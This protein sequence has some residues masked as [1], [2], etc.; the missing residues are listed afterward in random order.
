MH[1]IRTVQP[2]GAFAFPLGMLLVPDDID[3]VEVEQAR[4][5]LIEARE[6]VTWPE[7]LRGHELAHKGQLVEAAAQFA[8]ADEPISV[9]NRYVLE[10]DGV[11]TVALRNALPSHLADLVDVVRYTIGD[12]DHVPPASSTA[13]EV[14]ALLDAARASE[15][16]SH[17]DAAGAIALLHDAAESVAQSAAPLSAMLLGNAG[18][19]GHEFALDPDQALDDL[20]LACLGLVETDLV[21]ARAELHLRLGLAIH[22]AAAAGRRPL[23]DAVHEYYNA[24]QLVD[25]ES[26]P[27]T[28]A[29]A[30]LNLGAAYLTMPMIE[31]TDQL[32]SGI[33]MQSLRAALGVFTRDEHPAEW[34]SAT[35]N[36]A[37][38]L[39][40]TPST[41]QGDNI[42][43]AVERYEE[44]LE[45]RSRDTDP[46]GR[47]RILANLGNALAHLGIFE[48]AKSRLYEA[49]YLFEEALDHDSVMAVRSI[50]DEISRETVPDSGRVTHALPG[51][52]PV[53]ATDEPEEVG[54]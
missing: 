50:L 41:H 19:I 24:L 44:V 23:K 25:E 16:L 35:L 51:R 33:A 17:G 18:T 31:A 45:T 52:I 26:A 12:L 14:V 22:A 3:D 53:P 1:Q 48:H 42:V 9:F 29:S 10:P 7:A 54:S 15:L 20:R 2:I 11:D 8:Q 37:N 32:R 39:V 40:Y 4:A 38:A 34:A 21:L 49:R 47:A 28:W 43:E 46:L 30:H 27:Y 6:P 5:T 36:L 13:P